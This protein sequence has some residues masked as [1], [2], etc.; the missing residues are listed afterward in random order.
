METN[1]LDFGTPISF[2]WTA[3]YLD[4]KTQTRRQWKDTHVAKF[5]RAYDRAAAAGQQLRVPAIDK[6]YHAGGKQIGWCVIRDRPYKQRLGDMPE[7]DLL[8]EGGMSATVTDFISKYFK[9]DADLEVWVIDFEFVSDIE[10]ESQN[11]APEPI[12][13]PPAKPK[14]LET[15]TSAK[16]DEHNTPAF[17]AIAARSVMGGIDLDPMSN[18][19]T[20]ETIRAYRIFTKADDGLTKPWLGR[21]WLNP[22]FSLADQAVPKLIASYESGDIF[23]AVLLLKS[24]V[25]TK[26]Y[27]LLY[28]YPFVELN[29]RVN[30]TAP[31]NKDG[32]PFAT[33]LFY[34]GSNFTRWREVMSVY[35]RVHPGA[36]LFRELESD[37]TELLAQLASMEALVRR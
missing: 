27:Q 6:G 22:P 10:G 24:A 14:T 16:S 11:P 9:G 34:L 35:G 21:V 13:N 26:R 7:Q 37:R 32:A 5:L 2:G 20:N 33:V 31:G 8:A 3:Q 1:Y 4:T 15:L 29:K 30:Y 36:Q 18:A 19:I 17:L 12:Q 23:E 25:E 28:D